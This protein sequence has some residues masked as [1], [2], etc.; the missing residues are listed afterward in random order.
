MPGLG[1][2]DLHVTGDVGEDAFYYEFSDPQCECAQS[3]GKESFFHLDIER[4]LLP[5]FRDAKIA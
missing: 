3:E 5:L 1:D 4:Q 2:G